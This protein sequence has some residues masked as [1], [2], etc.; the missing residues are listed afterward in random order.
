VVASRVGGTPELIEDG[1][2]GLLVPPN[3]PRALA[4]AI[5]RVL[6]DPA[7]AAWLSVNGRRRVKE[8]FSFEAVVR[9]TEDLYRELLAAKRR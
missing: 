3:D 9:K 2:H 7:L 1:R 6:G 8:E 4:N 5:G